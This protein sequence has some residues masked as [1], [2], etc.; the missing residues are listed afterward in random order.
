MDLD[1]GY[2]DGG[3]KSDSDGGYSGRACQLGPGY[4]S[5]SNVDMDHV[6]AVNGS[7]CFLFFSAFCSCSLSMSCSIY[8]FLLIDRG[9]FVLTF[10]QLFQGFAKVSQKDG[11]RMP[12]VCLDIFHALQRISRLVNKNHGAFKPFMARLRDAGFI[13]NSEDI[14]E[15]IF[16]DVACHVDRINDMKRPDMSRDVSDLVMDRLQHA[17]FNFASKFR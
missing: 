4:D 14:K 9:E 5:D 6:S 10:A 2:E 16:V 17:H 13:V 15:A 3:G 11:M 12:K 7:R 1:E 8:H